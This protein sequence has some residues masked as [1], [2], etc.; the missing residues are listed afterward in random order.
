MTISTKKFAAGTKYDTYAEFH[1]SFKYHE[2][3]NG[4][5]YNRNTST[6]LSSCKVSNINP[7][8]KYYYARFC[9]RMGPKTWKTRANDLLKNPSLCPAM[10][11][12]KCRAKSYLCLSDVNLHHNHRSEYMRKRTDESKKLQQSE[13][14]KKSKRTV[15]PKKH[16]I[17]S[18]IKKVEQNALTSR[19]TR[20][21]KADWSCPSCKEH[22][23]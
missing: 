12:L 19:T 7:N 3:S 5:E 9:C 21:K 6:R 4:F 8:L 15:V 17:K 1:K 13:E 10:F 18:T 2:Y 23:N 11:T 16:E 22:H 20:N 14:V